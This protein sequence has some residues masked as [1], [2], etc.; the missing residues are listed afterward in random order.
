MYPLSPVVVP[1]PSIQFT[2]FT[3]GTLFVGLNLTWRCEVEISGRQLSGV[4]ASVEWIGPNGAVITSDRR[5]T[6]GDTL[7]KSPGREY[8]KTLTF[9][10]LSAGD[11]GSYSCSATVMPTTSNSLVTNAVGT[12]SDSLSVASKDL[13]RL[14]YK[15][16]IINIVLFCSRYNSFS[17]P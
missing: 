15:I 10:P 3:L 5:I 6:V 9:L 17:Q 11:S 7:E 13:S 4:S 8:Q 2:I 16:V 14:L 12:E 1:T